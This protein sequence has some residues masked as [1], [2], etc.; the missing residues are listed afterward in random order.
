MTEMENISRSFQLQHNLNISM[1]SWQ[2]MEVA[3]EII[4]PCQY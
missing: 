3:P 2:Q 4:H 1:Q